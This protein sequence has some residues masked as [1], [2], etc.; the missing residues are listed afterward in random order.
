MNAFEKNPVGAESGASQPPEFSYQNQLVTK[1]QNIEIRLQNLGRPYLLA[2]SVI[3]FVFAFV[4]FIGMVVYLS[5]YGLFVFSLFILTGLYVS[6][7]V[8]TIMLAFKRTYN[9]LIFALV[10]NSLSLMGSI[11][12]FITPNIVASLVASILIIFPLA[13]FVIIVY[14]KVLSDRIQSLQGFMDPANY[15]SI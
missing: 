9:I 14:T 4:T 12:S 13:A 2:H 10:S 1:R 5:E 11:L 15:S 8:S 3:V 6:A 7:G